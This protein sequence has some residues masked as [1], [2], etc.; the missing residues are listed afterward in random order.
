MTM[1]GAGRR[2]PAFELPDVRGRTIRFC[3]DAAGLKVLVFYKNTCPTCQF[4]M[5]YFD[6]LYA[7]T[8]SRG[9]WFHAVSQDSPDEA[10]EFARAY[11][12]E[13]PQLIDA[14]P[15]PVS[16]LYGLMNVPTFLLIDALGKVELTTPA[17]V[18]V[19]LLQ[20]AQRLA[21]QSEPLFSP[22]E[23]VPELKPG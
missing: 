6:R 15:H 12:L 8:V 10:L 19:E 3:P 5:P 18:K 11:R 13:M 9:T 1:L 4:A 23:K 22:D 17:F 21:P 7:R 20:A 14:A 2:A 16:R